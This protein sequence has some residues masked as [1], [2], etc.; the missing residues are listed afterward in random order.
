MEAQELGS[1]FFVGHVRE[2]CVR[3]IVGEAHGIEKVDNGHVVAVDLEA[4]FLL[5]GVSVAAP[6][7]RQPPLVSLHHRVITAG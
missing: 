4:S 5:A 6:V 7:F 2:L 1:E 3:E